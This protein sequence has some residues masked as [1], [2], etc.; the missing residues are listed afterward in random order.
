M[1]ILT[2]M[3]HTAQQSGEITSKQPAT[4]IAWSFQYLLFSAVTGWLADSGS[5]LE[6]RFLAAF[7]LA[8]ARVA[9]STGVEGKAMM[10]RTSPL[11]LPLLAHIRRDPPA[12]RRQLQQEMGDVAKLDILFNCICY[13][14]DPEDARWIPADHHA[15]FMR[16]PR[17]LEIFASFNGRNVRTTEGPDW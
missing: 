6:K 10:M 2:H 5:S 8:A 14:F 7:D 12:A 16:H 11:G 1:Q 13:F 9:T 15:D 4:Q 17:Q 3:F